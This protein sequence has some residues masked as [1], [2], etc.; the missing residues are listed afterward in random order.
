MMMLNSFGKGSRLIVGLMLAM[1]SA[2]L[3][4][5]ALAIAGVFTWGAD[6][7][8]GSGVVGWIVPLAM[9]VLI[10]VLMFVLGPRRMMRQSMGGGTPETAL[11]ILRKRFARGELSRDQF[12]EME[13][14]LREHPQQAGATLAE[15]PGPPPRQ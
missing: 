8:P 13:K 11:D 9:P 2:R 6:R 4:V 15:E 14:V 10:I 1:I 12:E 7:A 3:L 5:F